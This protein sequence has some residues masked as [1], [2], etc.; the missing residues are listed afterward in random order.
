MA[1]RLQYPFACAPPSPVDSSAVTLYPVVVAATEY[2]A[3]G[4]AFDANGPN[5]WL[6]LAKTGATLDQLAKHA[7]ALH[8]VLAGRSEGEDMTRETFGTDNTAN[9]QNTRGTVRA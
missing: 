6:L 7:C 9:D 1:C 8:D 2:P 5:S 4:H 3:D